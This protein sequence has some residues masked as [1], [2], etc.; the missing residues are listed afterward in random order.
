V[1]EIYHF[2]LTGASETIRKYL[3]IYLKTSKKEKGP[4]LGKGINMAVSSLLSLDP[5]ED[6]KTVLIYMDAENKQ[7]SYKDPLLLGSPLVCENSPALFTKAAF[8]RYHMEGERRKLGGRV[9]A[10]LGVPLTGMFIYKKLINLNY[11]LLYPLSGEIGIDR[12]LLWSIETAKKYGI[13]MSTLLHLLGI[14]KKGETKLSEEN[15]LQVYLGINMDQPL[16][17]GKSKREIVSGV[18]KMSEDIVL[19][20]FHIM[21]DRIKE[22]WKSPDEFMNMFRDF[23]EDSIE[24]WM[25]SHD[26]KHITGG[27][28]VEDLKRNVYEV[29]EEH[30]NNLYNERGVIKKTYNKIKRLF[31]PYDED[32]LPPIKSIKDDMGNKFDEFIERLTESI[33][34]IYPDDINYKEKI[35][36]GNHYLL[37]SP[38]DTF[39]L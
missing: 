19:S 39:R 17:E 14:N 12:D 32:S 37:S 15:F 11:P 13:E 28:E 5:S 9:N 22:R 4:L 18:R 31:N 25:E 35:M 33:E 8:K 36:E 16:A 3:G 10:S 38:A 29:V 1:P 30:T 6:K 34:K 2:N 7:V 21:G 24:R 27:I 23:Q 20:A 26:N